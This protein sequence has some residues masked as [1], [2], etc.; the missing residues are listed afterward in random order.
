MADTDLR[1]YVMYDHPRDYPNEVVVRR[2]TVA[3]AAAVAGPIVARGP[4]IA[5]VRAQ[6]PRPLYRLDSFAEDDPKIAEV[7]L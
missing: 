1:I 6:L 4:T 2:W 5:S 7:W 3:G